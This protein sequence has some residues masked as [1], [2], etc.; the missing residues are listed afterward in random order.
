MLRQV[1]ARRLV[2]SLCGGWIALT[3]LALAGC[4]HSTP[5]GEPPKGSAR[6]NLE[7]ICNAYRKASQEFKRPPTL[8]EFK[9]ALKGY[10]DP[11]QLLISPRDGQPFVLVIGVNVFNEP[12][13]AN[14]L[15]IAYEKAGKDG[16]RMAVFANGTVPPD[17]FTDEEMSKFRY[18]GGHKFQP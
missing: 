18:G 9:T 15:I 8:D 5:P 17:G 14:P 12:T 10:G 13:P 16:K 3:V 2:R 6:A 1:T 7:A 11:D 4:G